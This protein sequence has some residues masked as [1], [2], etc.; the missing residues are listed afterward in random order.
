MLRCS[1]G[2]SK[3]EQVLYWI[4]IKYH[5]ITITMISNF[6]PINVLPDT[7]LSTP[8]GVAAD[9]IYI[10][11]VIIYI[12]LCGQNNGKQWHYTH[13]NTITALQGNTCISLLNIHFV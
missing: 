2:V 12:P 8:T 9:S 7:K 13:L 4:G 1:P 10:A 11:Y 5:G 3:L 6:I